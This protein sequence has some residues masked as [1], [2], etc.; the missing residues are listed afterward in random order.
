MLPTQWAALLRRADHHLLEFA[1]QAVLRQSTVWT[2][3]SPDSGA[4]PTWIFLNLKA[5]S[6]RHVGY[7]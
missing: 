1:A 5:L 6:P 7:R 2:A 3:G 4:A